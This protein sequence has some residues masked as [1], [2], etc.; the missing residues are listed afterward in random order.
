MVIQ[1]CHVS[2][3]ELRLEEQ[4][5][6]VP[7]LLKVPANQEGLVLRKESTECSGRDARKLLMLSNLNAEFQK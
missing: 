2:G 6:T 3:T 5:H 7:A 4:I 1:Y